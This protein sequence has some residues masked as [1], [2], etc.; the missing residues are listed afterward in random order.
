LALESNGFN[1]VIAGNEKTAVP[2]YKLRSG[3]DTQGYYSIIDLENTSKGYTYSLSATLEKTFNFGLNASLSY[4]Y[5]HSKSIYDGTSSVAYSNWKY[6]YAYDSNNPGLS[7]STF[8]IPN[9]I[10]F[11]LGYTTPKYLNDILST[12]VSLIY[13]G[14]N[15]MRFSLTMNESADFNGDGQKGNTVLYIPTSDE[16]KQMNFTDEANRTSFENWIDNNNYAKN[17]RGQFSKRNC[18]QAPWENRIDLHLA[19]NI[20][21]MKAWGSKLQLTCDIINFANMLNKHWGISYAS[22]YNVTPLNYAYNKTAAAYQ[23]SYNTK[24]TVTRSDIYSRW[25]MQIGAKI[26]F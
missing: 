16:I 4:T 5:G 17:H 8:D 1:Y 12:D 18:C 26:V 24:G 2:A 22:A 25:H 15:G 21:V 19:E 23:Y 14:S 6:N 20:F 11:N 13:T 9:R 3:D 7:Y 10:V